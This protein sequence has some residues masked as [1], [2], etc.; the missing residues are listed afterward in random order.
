[1]VEA[2]FLGHIISSRG[3][4]VGSSKVQKIL[5]WPMPWNPAEVR[6]FNGLVNYITKFIAALTEHF[7]VLSRLTRK[8][9]EFRWIS[10]EQKAF[11][12]IK[13][14]ARNTLICR[15]IDYNN[16]DLIYVVT[17]ASNDAIGGYYGQRKDY[18]TMPPA[19]FYS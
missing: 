7:V 18:R 3:T 14:L 2:Q 1:M 11:D 5:D 10:V 12:D 19:S 4:E 16:L 13:R 8:G 17:N 15:S 9:T 6:A